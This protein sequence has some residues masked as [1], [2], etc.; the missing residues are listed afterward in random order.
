VRQQLRQEWL[1]QQPQLLQWLPLQQQEYG[2]LLLLLLLL[3]LQTQVA[4]QLC[5]PAQRL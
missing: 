5:S 1:P 3:V 4:L 2:M